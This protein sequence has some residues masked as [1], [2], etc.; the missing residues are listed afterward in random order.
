MPHCPSH[1]WLWRAVDK[2]TLLRQG[3]ASH[4]GPTG[5]PPLPHQGVWNAHPEQFGVWYLLVPTA[6]F[7]LFPVLFLFLFFPK[8]KFLIMVT[9]FCLHHF[10]AG[11]LRMIKCTIWPWF[12][13]E[14]AAHHTE[15]IARRDGIGLIYTWSF[16]CIY[17]TLFLS[18]FES[19]RKNY[20][21]RGFPYSKK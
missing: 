11:M 18:F 1:M 21:W 5:T 10:L 7:P 6:S 8:K 14:E 16:N 9:D 12:I 4:L 13:F 20:I 19:V 3:N 2:E 15:T 17:N